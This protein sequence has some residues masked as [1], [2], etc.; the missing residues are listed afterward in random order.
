MTAN[1]SA[2]ALTATIDL[3]ALAHNIGVLRETSGTGVIAVVKADAYGHG[4]VPVARAALAAGAE[5]LGVAHVTEALALRQAGIDAHITSWLHTPST[6]FAAAVAA[7][8][9][10]AVSSPR[11]LA[12]VVD[13]AREAGITATATVK[14]DTGLNRSGVAVDEWD[15]MA[16]AL[17]K[18]H[19]EE[20]IMLRAIMTHLVRGDEP[21]HPLNSQQADS[22]DA[23]AAD[24]AR[25]GAPPQIMHLANSPAALVRPD[26]SRD[27]VRPGIALYGRTPLPGRGDFGLIPVMTL[28]GEISLVKRVAR[29]QGVSYSHTWVAPQDTVVAV[30]PAGYADGVPRTLSG[31]FEVLV[32]GRRFPAVGRVCMDQF[33]IDLGPDGGGVAEGDL[34]ELFG[35]GHAGGSTAADWADATDTI[36]Y[37]ILS[38]IR[39]RTVRRYVGGE[40]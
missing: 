29:G 26:L 5:E 1:P 28:T 36:D 19:A 35:R 37:E 20:S 4:A 14:V 27:L 25:L 6:D 31:R 3:D 10:I 39:G 24:L 8:I 34:A 32:N 7:D 13:A 22:L 21:D 17:A 9:D 40:A 18:A 16:V 38:A 33:V 12:A 2:A 30:V 23:A 15:S 11:Q